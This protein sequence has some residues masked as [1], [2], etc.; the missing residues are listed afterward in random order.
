MAF[1]FSST[2]QLSTAMDVMV[3]LIREEFERAY[4]QAPTR[5]VVEGFVRAALDRRNVLPTDELVEQL[6][7]HLRSGAEIPHLK[8]ITIRHCGS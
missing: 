6:V 8:G 5:E 2:I 4:A 3:R 1:S 7:D